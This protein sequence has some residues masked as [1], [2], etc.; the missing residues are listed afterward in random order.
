MNASNDSVIISFNSISNFIT[1]LGQEFKTKYKPVKL[2]CHLIK[3]T[4]LSHNKAIL[5]HVECFRVFCVENREA[6]RVKS[7]ANLKGKITYSSRVYIDIKVIL[8]ASDKDTQEVIWNHLLCISALVDPAGKA[9]DILRKNL[10][11]GKTGADETDFLANIISKVEA[12]VKPDSDPMAAVSSIM[13]SGIFTDLIGGMQSGLS[14]GKLDIGK[15][16]GAV[17]G[18]VSSMGNQAGGDDPMAANMIGM[19]SGL[20]KN[21]GNMDGIGNQSMSRPNMSNPKIEELP[22]DASAEMKE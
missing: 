10:E 5:K 3:K 22:S 19:M 16:L 2:Y 6:F 20:M 11:E 8:E 12:N 17:Q 18:M 7:V 21:L 9:K 1:E 13:S 15:L 4:N 14:S